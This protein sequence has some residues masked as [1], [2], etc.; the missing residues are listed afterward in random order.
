MAMT[1]QPLKKS[2]EFGGEILNDNEP[3]FYYR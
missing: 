1:Q 2:L 3:W